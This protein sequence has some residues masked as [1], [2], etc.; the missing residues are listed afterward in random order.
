M[1]SCYFIT[2]LR[3]KEKINLLVFIST[4][5]GRFIESCQMLVGRKMSGSEWQRLYD[6]VKV[7]FTLGVFNKFIK[8]SCDIV[9]WSEF[10]SQVNDVLIT[11]FHLHRKK[12]RWGC[13]LHPQTDLVSF[14][15]L[16]DRFS[17]YKYLSISFPK[18]PLSILSWC[19]NLSLW[20]FLCASFNIQWKYIH[21]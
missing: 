6:V 11:G 20:F 14:R 8:Q 12:C 16:S 1:F 2:F 7:K 19:V 5:L 21:V 9:L 10:I 15:D 4:W 3:K 13:F 18:S 17:K